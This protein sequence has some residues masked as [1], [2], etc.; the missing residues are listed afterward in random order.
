MGAGCE[1]VTNIVLLFIS[2]Y[3]VMYNYNISLSLSIVE[4]CVLGD[5]LHKN[6]YS[7]KK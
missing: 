7:K 2:D 6:E 3:D 5:I 1:H 4:M